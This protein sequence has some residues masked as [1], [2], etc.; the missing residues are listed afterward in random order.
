MEPEPICDSEEQSVGI[1]EYIRRGP[2]LPGI[3]KYLVSDFIVNEIDQQ[4]NV[5]LFASKPEHG[6]QPQP[7]DKK[8]QDK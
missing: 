2:Q 4:G 7:S 3:Q 1:T 5:V 6:K 8:E